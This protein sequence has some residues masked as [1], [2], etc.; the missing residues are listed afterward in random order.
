MRHVLFVAYDYPPA[1]SQGASLRS[2]KFVRYLPDH[3]W[4]PHVLAFDPGDREMPDDGV[5]RVKSRLPMARPFNLRP[6]GWGAAAA[7]RAIELARRQKFDLV[8]LTC[9]PFPPGLGA[10]KM[11]RTLALPLV[12]DFR[13]AW[14]L[15]PYAEPSSLMRFAGPPMF[16]WMERRL[17]NRSNAIL[18]NTPS[19]L[20]AYQRRYPGWADRRRLLPNGYDEDDFAGIDPPAPAPSA[21]LTLAHA[22]DFAASRRKSELILNALSAINR[23]KERVKLQFIG[24]QGSTGS[25]RSDISATGRLPHAEAL[26]QIGAADVLLVFQNPSDEIVTPV[27]GKT[28]EYLRSGKPILAVAPPGDNVDLVAKFADRCECVTNFSLNDVV[29]AL[30]RLF[31]DWQSGSLKTRQ[32]GPDFTEQFER[33]RLTARLASL[34][35]DLAA[36]T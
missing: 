23:D 35:D 17:F 21:T 10:V 8:Y 2:Q 7:A 20:S 26:R 6:Y 3:G 36:Q 13:D 27:A 18:L 32:A 28:Y 33:R 1:A 34:F 29:A 5:A 12:T 14:T 4:Q 19:A 11:A 30:E 15:S 31:D 9:P 25:G 22:G 16:A 24:D